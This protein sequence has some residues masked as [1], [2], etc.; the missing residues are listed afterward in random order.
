MKTTKFLIITLLC[1]GLASAADARQKGHRHR[2]KHGKGKHHTAAKAKPAAPARPAAPAT[3]APVGGAPPAHHTL[4]PS[5]AIATPGGLWSYNA[6]LTSGEIQANDGFTI[7]DFGGYVAGSIVAPADWVP[8]TALSGSPF[9]ASA[10]PDDPTLTNLTFTYIGATINKKI[11]AETFTGFNASTTFTLD[12]AEDWRSQDHDAM[13]H[14]LATPASGTILVPAPGPAVPD[15]GA[16]VA[17][18]GIG[19]TGLEAMRRLLRARKA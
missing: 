16:T 15:G 13:S 1:V 3:A 8:S 6:D 5:V 14:L 9:G 4:T 10:G 11:G 17:L 19:L 12:T 18:L 2:A 7:F